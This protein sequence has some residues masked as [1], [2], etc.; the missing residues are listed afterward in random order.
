MEVCLCRRHECLILGPAS[1]AAKVRPGCWR[2][3]AQK[4]YSGDRSR[5]QATSAKPAI[6]M[7][8][9]LRML[10]WIL[11][12]T[13]CSST[14]SV[15]P[16]HSSLS[17]HLVTQSITFACSFSSCCTSETVSG[18]CVQCKACRCRSYVCALQLHVSCNRAATCALRH[19]GIPCKR[20]SFLQMIAVDY[21]LEIIE[22]GMPRDQ[23]RGTTSGRRSECGRG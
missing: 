9:R 3:D 19:L 17:V 16:T 21:I 5:G 8:S 4:A 23:A 10:T 15:S 7:A 2:D 11:N 14:I 13:P 22:T 18:P 6:H 1:H 20:W 12:F